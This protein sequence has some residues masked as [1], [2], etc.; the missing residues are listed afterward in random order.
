MPRPG[1]RSFSLRGRA[2]RGGRCNFGKGR[3]ALPESPC[4]FCK[5][6]RP[7]PARQAPPS[8]PRGRTARRARQIFP[9]KSD[10]QTS[11][12]TP[13][14]LVCRPLSAVPGIRF[15]LHHRGC[16]RSRARR[17]EKSRLF[18]KS[19]PSPENAS[20][21]DKK[22]TRPRRKTSRTSVKHTR[23]ATLLH[24]ADPGPCPLTGYRHIP[25]NSRMP[26]RRRILGFV[27]SL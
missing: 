4:H 17:Q 3:Q 21:G 6:R 15:P 2:A 25:G 26:T 18:D 19:N 8:A 10:A 9:W 27:K 12:K 11:E 20:A 13:L 14:Y 24:E 22:N 23:G 16:S 7:A 1:P 5:S